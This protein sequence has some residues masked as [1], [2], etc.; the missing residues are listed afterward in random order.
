MLRLAALVAV[1]IQCAFNAQCGAVL[2]GI[3][4]LKVKGMRPD[5]LAEGACALY[6]RHM[7][8]P[9][10]E[11]RHRKDVVSH[12]VLRLAYCRTGGWVL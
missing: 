9:T 1:S 10:R 6:E 7:G 8:A 11:E 2:K 5:Q 4:D 12:H 3:D